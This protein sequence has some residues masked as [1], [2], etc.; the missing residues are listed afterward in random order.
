MPPPQPAG[1]QPPLIALPAISLILLTELLTQ[2]DNF[3]HSTPFIA[4]DLADFLDRRHTHPRFTA[5]NVIGELSLAAEHLRRL[6]TGLD[7]ATAA[8]SHLTD[9]LGEQQ[10]Q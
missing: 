6:T 9:Q 10:G 5:E 8:Y 7:P 3:L 1:E 2:L 4:E